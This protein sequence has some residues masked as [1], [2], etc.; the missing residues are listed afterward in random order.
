M[1]P[2]MI[3]VPREYCGKWIAWNHERTKIVASGRTYRETREA[4]EKAGEPRPILTK[5][6]EAAKR[7][8]G[9]RS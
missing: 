9:G 4:A 7:F 8:V 5:A 6:P 1:K 3:Q 2:K